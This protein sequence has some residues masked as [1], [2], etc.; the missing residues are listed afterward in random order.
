[1]TGLQVAFSPTLG[2]AAV[3]PEVAALVTRAAEAFVELGAHVEQADP[4]FTDPVEAFEVLW[5]AGA[6]TSTEHL[7]PEQRTLLDPGLA[8]ICEQGARYSAV[9]YLDAHAGRAALGTM[10]G[11]FHERY[12]LLLTPTV[13]L[14][15]FEVGREVPTGSA[16]RRWTSWT[17]FTYPFNMTQQPAASVPCGW[18][19]K[20]LPVGLQV[21]GPRF[22]DAL[23]LAA[24]AAF[25]QARPWRDQRPPL[26]AGVAGGP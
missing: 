3:D 20:G 22:A 13:P 10:L 18:T 9:Q 4:G 17:P 6:A 19:S 2:F 21:V 26:P 8:E 23:V 7:T 12:D 14:S 1:V 25:E 24:C 5:F 16:A 15:A 11:A